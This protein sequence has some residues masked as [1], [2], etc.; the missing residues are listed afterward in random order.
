MIKGS[1]LAYS[2]K[3]HSWDPKHIGGVDDNN[4]SKDITNYYALRSGRG[5]ENACA[6]DYTG[7]YLKHTNA[8]HNKEESTVSM[9]VPK[10]AK[11]GSKLPKPFTANDN[12]EKFY[13]KE[14]HFTPLMS[15]LSSQ[16]SDFSRARS[17]SP[18]QYPDIR[19]RRRLLLSRLLSYLKKVK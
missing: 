13:K 16:K 4:A 19:F 7:K 12:G 1:E 18:S 5:L 8:L 14:R 6:V 15:D 10:L 17:I 3:P 2:Q 9:A 11:E